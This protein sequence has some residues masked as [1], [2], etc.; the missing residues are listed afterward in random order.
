MLK[1]TF[2]FQTDFPD[3]GFRGRPAV[4]L[5]I[6]NEGWQFLCI[7]INEGSMVIGLRDLSCH[8]VVEEQFAFSV[9]QRHAFLDC[10]VDEIDNFFE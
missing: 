8:L 6:D 9:F 1:I 10:I 5:K 4:G 2:L 3:L 7:R